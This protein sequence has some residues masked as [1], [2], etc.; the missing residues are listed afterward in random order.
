MHM[1]PYVVTENFRLKRAFELF[2]AMGLRHLFVV[3]SENKLKG[4][5]TRKDLI[6]VFSSYA[7]QIYKEQLKDQP[8]EHH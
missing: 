8:S 7:S 2:R 1:S 5:L 4:L 3:D 6:Q